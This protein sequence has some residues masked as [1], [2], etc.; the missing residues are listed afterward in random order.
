MK[1]KVSFLEEAMK[2]FRMYRSQLQLCGQDAEGLKYE[3]KAY[4]N[5]CTELNLAAP[6]HLSLIFRML[7]VNYETDIVSVDMKNVL[8]YTVDAH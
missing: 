4:K 1:K 6:Y 8:L 7:Q 3:K 5:N 2:K